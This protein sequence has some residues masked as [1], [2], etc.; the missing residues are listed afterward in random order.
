ML[1]GC[2]LDSPWVL[3]LCVLLVSV[4][5]HPCPSV[6]DAVVRC[7]LW[8]PCF[9]LQGENFHNGEKAEENVHPYPGLFGWVRV[10]AELKN[11]VVY[12]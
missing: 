1:L 8:Q 2:M 6:C 5:T 4:V 3:R 11:E 10:L 7:E 12:Q 9:G